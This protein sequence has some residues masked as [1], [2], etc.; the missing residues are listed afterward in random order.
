MR[1]FQILYLLLFWGLYGFMSYASIVSLK[2]TILSTTKNW[3][4]KLLVVYSVGLLLSFFLLYVWPNSAR[5]TGEYSIYLMYNSLLALD[6]VFKLP[7]TVFFLFSFILPRKKATTVHFIGLII[8]ICVG[9]SVIYGVLLGR[10]SYVVNRIELEFENL[11][12]R[13]DGY[14]IV[15]I[16]DTHLGGFI[17]SKK[18]MNKTK[19]EIETINPDLLLFT[20]DLV[21]NFAKEL[22]GWQGLFTELTQNKKAF[23]ILG[24]HDYGNYSSWESETAKEENFKKIVDANQSYGFKLLRNEHVKLYSGNDSIFLIG[25]ENWG[26]P[27]FPQYANLEKAM[28]GV[29]KNTFKIL[30]THDPAHWEA[31]VKKRQDVDFTLSGH[32]HGMQ[33]GIKKAGILFSIASLAHTNWAGLYCYGNSQLYVNTGLGTVGIPMRINMPPELTVFTLKRV[34]ID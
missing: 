20:G 9:S 4:A 30:M 12:E 5:E 24:N 27:P 17:H 23:S 6:F 2:R 8:S 13:F 18:I 19:R 32:T 1:S 10:N 25:V 3:I 29:T 22:R 14:K 33:W 28:A 21:N 34:E 26:H 31:V 11:P 16:S 15:Q 7:L